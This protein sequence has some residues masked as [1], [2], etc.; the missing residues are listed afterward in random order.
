MTSQFAADARIDEISRTLSLSAASEIA[1][2]PENSRAI[3]ED[4]KLSIARK[5]LEITPLAKGDESDFTWDLAGMLPDFDTGVFY[6]NRSSAIAIAAA[7]F[8]GWL[9][10]G[11][12]SGLLN[13]ISM[14]GDILRAAL[15]FCAVW[16]EE[17]LTANPSARNRILKACGWLSLAGFAA[18]VGSGF[19]RIASGFRQAIFGS[20]RPGLFRGAWLILGAGLILVFFSRKKGSLDIATLKKHLLE[21]TTQRLNLAC[22]FI[23]AI[24]FRSE[25]KNE[26]PRE[27]RY[28][29][30]DDCVLAQGVT[31]ILDGLEAGPKAFLGERLVQAGYN[32]PEKSGRGEAIVWDDENMPALYDSIGF[33]H[34]G[35]SCM[36]LKRPLV[37]DGKTVK[38]LVQCVEGQDK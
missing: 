10:G 28:C 36:V 26:R 19:F 18:R 7:V 15:I 29:P 20:V 35:D 5:A 31:E 3:L 21:Q 12:I 9:F 22:S 14:G 11:I 1:A 17:Y 13:L 24:N 8:L 33:V 30:R 25:C 27:R 2:K 34:P 37:K 38:G 6:I 32:L 16:L 4:L 23:A